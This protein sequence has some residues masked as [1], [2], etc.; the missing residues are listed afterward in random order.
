MGDFNFD[1]L[2]YESLSGTDN[3]LNTWISFNFQPQISQ[4]TTITNH[5]ATLIEN[6]YFNSLEHFNVSGN[7]CYD[8]TDH[9]PNFLIIC[10]YSSLPANTKIFQREYSNF[11]EQTQI[12]DIESANW[13]ELLVI[14]LTQV[15]CLTVSTVSYLK[16]LTNIYL[17]SNYQNKN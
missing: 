3:F 13:V 9:L 8:L 12:N 11:D 10:K 7:L 16:L 5:S 2:K 4:P 17:S 15:L 1:L 6:I 14:F